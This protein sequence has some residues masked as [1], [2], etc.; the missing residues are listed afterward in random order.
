VLK[1]LNKVR[2]ENE[3]RILMN[4]E[5]MDIIYQRMRKRTNEGLTKLEPSMK[6]QANSLFYDKKA[7]IYT[8]LKEQKRQDELD[9]QKL[10]RKTHVPLNAL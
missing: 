7:D 6:K 1:S 5:A 2:Q 3:G 10:E 4:F 9:L 8:L